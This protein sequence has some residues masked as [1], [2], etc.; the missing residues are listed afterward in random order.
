MSTRPSRSPRRLDTH[1]LVRESLA[2]L[3]IDKL[4]LAIHDVSFPSLPDED[5]GR[6]TPYSRGAQDFLEAMRDIGFDG[7]QLGPQGQTTPGNLSPYD[8]SV[9]SKSQLS[10]P[11]SALSG[12]IPA[13]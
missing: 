2:L 7:V 12:I 8:G 6:G 13:A 5:I 9:F 1:A 4:V 10:I 11:L 3:G